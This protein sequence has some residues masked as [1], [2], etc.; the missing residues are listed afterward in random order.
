MLRSTGALVSMAWL[1]QNGFTNADC[2]LV[3]TV[4]P[5]ARRTV[6]AA[7]ASAAGAIG[8]LGTAIAKVA[9]T[10]AGLTESQA[11][12]SSKIDAD[13]GA[14]IEICVKALT[15]RAATLHATLNTQWSARDTAL[16]RQLQALEA[17]QEVQ[18]DIRQVRCVG[19]VR[20]L[21]GYVDVWICGYV[22]MWMCCVDVLS[23][24]GVP[25]CVRCCA[26][27]CCAVLCSRTLCCAHELFC[28][29]FGGAQSWDTLC[30]PLTVCGRSVSP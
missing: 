8:T 11:L 10:R 22:D 23:L 16:D 30:C 19:A 7:A 3:A 18:A 12:S 6:T 13:V 5:V 4:A 26:T 2:D 24:C 20:V 27:L 28:L 17:Q 1:F 14:A 9:Q 21:C 15:A 29:F 25:V